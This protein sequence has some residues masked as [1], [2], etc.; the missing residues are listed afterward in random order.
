MCI[1][2][3]FLVEV[4]ALIDA[5]G[6]SS[7]APADHRYL[8]LELRVCRHKDWWG[9]VGAK[10]TK[11]MHLLSYVVSASTVQHRTSTYAPTENSP[12]PSIKGVEVESERVKNRTATPKAKAPAR[13]YE[14]HAGV[15]HQEHVA[16]Q[17]VLF[18]ETHQRADLSARARS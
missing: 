5:E 10:L 2:H 17:R 16:G 14:E 13:A 4:T 7:C 6:S 1:N 8:A 9:L 18:R 12:Y 3:S 15:K 11:C